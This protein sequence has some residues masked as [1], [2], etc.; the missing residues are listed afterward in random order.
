MVSLPRLSPVT[1]MSDSGN[2]PAFAMP[3]TDALITANC[4]GVK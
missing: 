4:A 2:G 3:P 1:N